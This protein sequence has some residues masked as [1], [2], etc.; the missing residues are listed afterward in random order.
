MSLLYVKYNT[1]FFNEIDN[2]S[3]DIIMEVFKQKFQNYI[4]FVEFTNFIRVL[5]LN[6]NKD[7]LEGLYLQFIDVNSH[8]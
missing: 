7:L 2:P 4:D 8:F 1:D 5:E 6:V 3:I